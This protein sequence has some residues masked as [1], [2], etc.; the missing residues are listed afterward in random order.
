[1]SISAQLR[2]I[3]IV[4]S[5]GLIAFEVVF[6]ARRGKSG[7]VAK[8]VVTLLAIGNIALVTFL[9]INHM[10]FPLNLDLMEGTILQHTQRAAQLAPIYPEPTPAYVP[11]SYN[12]LYYVLAAPFGWLMGVNLTTL[13]LVAILGMLG[14]GGIVFLAVRRKTGSVWWGLAAVGLFAAAYAVQDSY[15][16]NAHSDSWLLCA[17]L[18]G[19]YLIDSNRGRGWNVAGVLL[20]VA[21]FWFKQ[22]GA[23]FAVGGVLFLT[24]REGLRK[25]L[26]YWFVAIVLGPAL[27][28]LGGPA[29]F[30]PRF[31]YFTWEVPRRWSALGVDTL[32]RLF[33]F[34]ALS[35]PFLA[36]ASIWTTTKTFIKD[37][38]Q[39]NIWHVQLV[40]AIGSGLM[41]ALDYGSANNVFISLGTWFIILGVIGLYQLAKNVKLV[42]RFRL[43]LLALLCS[44]AVMLYNPISMVVPANATAA[45]DDLITTLN[46]IDGTVYAPSLGQLQ[47]GYTFYPAA[48][49]VALEDMVRGPNREERNQPGTRLLLDP[50]IHAKQP[51]YVLS[52]FPI[53]KLIPALAFLDNYYALE[54][55]FGD[56]FQSLAVLPKRFDH[57]WPRYLYRY[58]PKPEVSATPQSRIGRGG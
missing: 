36:L 40:F 4:A 10:S 28:V 22:H 49:W 31:H 35:Y 6:I 51:T 43:D 32:T 34:I 42:Q 19:T 18:L 44:F 58:A 20:L 12:P 27:Y 11:L 45:Y 38:S 47:R 52:N 8:P 29:I 50:L 41:G 30:G 17:T 48:H 1:M 21:A 55:D 37:R 16:D 33:S 24:W 25:S 39:L 57:G 2:L 23:L 54:K 56:R 14:S 5:I 13:R 3:A 15:L 53:D 9:A 46:D 26:L 7:G